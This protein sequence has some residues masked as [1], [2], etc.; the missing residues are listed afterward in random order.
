MTLD[1]LDALADRADAPPAE[2]PQ[3]WLPNGVYT[4]TFPCGTHRTLRV[5]TQRGGPL[6]GRRVV[7]LLIGPRNT[8]DYEAFAELTPPGVYVWKRYAKDRHAAYPALLLR[9]MRGERVDGHDVEVSRT[10]LRCNR[11]LTDPESVRTNL[12][13]ECRRA[14]RRSQ[15]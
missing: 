4:L 13:P 3:A 11:L 1:D 5:H 7:S 12:G 15:G 10:C 2:F 9:L 14:G 8:D 6:A